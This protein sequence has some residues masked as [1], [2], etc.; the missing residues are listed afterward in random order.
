MHLVI[1]FIWKV[2]GTGKRP[3]CL[4]RGLEK[5]HMDESIKVDM[6]CFTC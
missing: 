2:M 6:K 4:V 5:R 1:Y 3:V